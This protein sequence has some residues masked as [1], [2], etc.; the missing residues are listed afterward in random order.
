MSIDFGP[1]HF[2]VDSPDNMCMCRINKTKRPHGNVCVCR[3]ILIEN[4]IY[5]KLQNIRETFVV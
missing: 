2:A 3:F 4:K 5:E 1:F